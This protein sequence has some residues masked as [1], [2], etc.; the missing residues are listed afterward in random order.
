MNSLRKTQD[1]EVVCIGQAVVD[2]ITRG[3]EEDPRG[4]GRKRA[5]S[6]TLNPG[7]D[8]FNEAAVLAGLGRRVRLVCAVGGDAAGEV[9]RRE[10]SRKNVITDGMTLVPGLV[11]PVANMFVDTDGARSSVSSGAAMLPGYCPD[12][13][14]LRG[15]EVVSFAS[16]FRA[17]LDDPG[18]VCRLISEA[19]KGG[20]VICADTK[21]PLFRRIDLDDLAE[22]LPLIDYFFPNE[23]EAAFYSGLRGVSACETADALSKKGIRHVV[24]K[25][26]AAGCAACGEGMR[27]AMP[28][29]PGPV[30]DTTGAGDNF[31]AGFI[32][33]L[34]DG[35]GFES[36]CEAGLRVAAESIG[37]IGATL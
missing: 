23:E 33:R 16:L 26:G 14:L 11:T 25:A 4:L 22:V 32:D 18:T 20:A 34:L 36:C 13:A 1:P 7:G 2:C 29:I 17:P 12:P 37:H 9:L 28:A 21:L 6:I 31:V 19:K 10:A 35:G 15:A 8:A 5:K 27:F 24:V 3:M 30:V